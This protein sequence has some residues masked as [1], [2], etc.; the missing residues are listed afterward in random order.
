MDHSSLRVIESKM[1]IYVYIS[2]HTLNANTELSLPLS[3]PSWETQFGQ[4]W[5]RRNA[6][7]ITNQIFY[8]FSQM[9]RTQKAA[10]NFN[11][12]AY[13]Q[14]EMLKRIEMLNVNRSGSL[15]GCHSQWR[16]LSCQLACHMT[17]AIHITSHPAF[18]MLSLSLAPAR[19]HT[20]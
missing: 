1:H 11:F 2:M 3:L 8:C 20:P 7:S 12:K 4:K 19:T 15:T 16:T 17:H 6:I 10:W 5:H 9:A 14:N 18:D 13:K